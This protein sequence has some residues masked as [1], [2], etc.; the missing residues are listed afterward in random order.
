METQ[1]IW[2]WLDYLWDVSVVGYLFV[3][4]WVS[5]SAYP[6]HAVVQQ[7]VIAFPAVSTHMVQMSLAAWCNHV[8]S[9]NQL[10]SAQLPCG[11]MFDQDCKNT[12]LIKYYYNIWHFV[13]NT[14]WRLSGV[15]KIKMISVT[16]VK[17]PRQ[18]QGHNQ[19]SEH[20]ASRLPI[21]AAI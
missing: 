1:L 19:I 14:K 4:S 8:A 2:K 20:T 18:C 9:R 5:Q 13:N 12:H 10:S 15:M 21:A 6:W 11:Y 3:Q 16:T 7:S 17:E